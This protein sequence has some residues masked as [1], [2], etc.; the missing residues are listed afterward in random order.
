M[1]EISEVAGDWPVIFTNSYQDPSQYTFHTGYFAHSLDN[2]AYR[3][4]QYDIWDF[5]E[6]LNGQEVFYVP[7]WL[8]AEYKKNLT[9]YILPDGDSLFA[10]VFTDFQSLQRECII[11]KDDSLSFSK[12][13]FQTIQIDI[14]NPYPYAV[15]LDHQEMPVHFN[16]AFFRDGLLK[17]EFRITLPDTITTLIPGDKL[18]VK[19]SF[20]TGNFPS[21]SYRFA[22]TSETGC[23]YNVMSSKLSDALVTD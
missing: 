5:E 14:F 18:S 20:F 7:H 23:L 6:K 4:T 13:Q 19:C 10:K 1:I 12:E 11:I 9:K 2:L 15:R 17:S 3:R 21:G 8:T 22:I 16:A